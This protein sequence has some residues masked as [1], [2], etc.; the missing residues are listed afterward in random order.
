VVISDL[1]CFKRSCDQQSV[2]YIENTD[3]NF[4]MRGYEVQATLRDQ[5]GGGR[6]SRREAFLVK[7]GGGFRLIIDNDPRYSSLTGRLGRNGGKLT[8]GYSQSFIEKGVRRKGG[9]IKNRTE[10]PDGSL[11]LKV[12]AA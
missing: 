4:K 5:V 7:D 12:R 10:N 3:A 1:E 2:E 8:R 6:G 11:V 9:R